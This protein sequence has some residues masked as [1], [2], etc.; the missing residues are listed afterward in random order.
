MTWKLGGGEKR[1]CATLKCTH[2]M[3]EDMVV[4]KNRGTPKWMVYNGKPYSN[5]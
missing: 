4:S 3:E 5:G 2:K 1:G